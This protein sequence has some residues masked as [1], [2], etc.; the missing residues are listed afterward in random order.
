VGFLF[1]QPDEVLEYLNWISYYYAHM[2]PI[3]RNGLIGLCIALLLVGG[4][5]WISTHQ[6]TVPQNA[7]GKPLATSSIS[8]E[9]VTGSGDYT[10]E[11]VP[12]EPPTLGA[13][14]ISKDLPVDVQTILHSKIDAQYT[15]LRKDPTRVD[16]WLQLGV[17]RKIGG[18]F[19]GAVEAWDYVTAVAPDAIRA[20]AYGNLGDLYTYFLKDY[21]RAELN[22]KQ[23]IALSPQK[24]DYYRT[25]YYLYRDVYKTNT[26]AASDILKQGLAANPGNTDLLQ[27]QSLSPAPPGAP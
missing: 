14:S 26:T 5:Y 19:A 11:Q 23:A 7:V 22:F 13:I 18:D 15:I 9:G 3:Q 1:C 10:V 20:V 6:S 27:L 4:F 8:L 2:N 25:L 12:I 21:P 17:N 16:V 24:I